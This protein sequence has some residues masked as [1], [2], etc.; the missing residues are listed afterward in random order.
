MF[1]KLSNDEHFKQRLQFLLLILQVGKCVQE[2][3]IKVVTYL[4]VYIHMLTICKC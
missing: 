4:L 3:K 1:L 2:H